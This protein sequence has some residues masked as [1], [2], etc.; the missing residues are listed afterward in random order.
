VT[1][2]GCEQG[3]KTAAVL[4]TA[5]ETYQA[6]VG[7]SANAGPGENRNGADQK[8]QTYIPNEFGRQ[9]IVD[10]G[11][12]IIGLNDPNKASSI[13]AQGSSLSR[14]LNQLPFINATA[15][16][17]DYMFNANPSL[18]SNFNFWNVPTMVPA[19]ALSIPAAL[20]NANISWITQVKRPDSIRSPTTKSLIR[21]D[22]RATAGISGEQQ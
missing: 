9:K 20:N 12:N 5:G 6:L 8:S 15:G 7:Y 1:G 21:I 19:A 22:P 13:G 14:A 11:M 3:A 4:S 16:L 18:E 10:Q 2:V 17:H